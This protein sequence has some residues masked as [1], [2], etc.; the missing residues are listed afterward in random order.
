M[1]MLRTHDDKKISNIARV[2][3]LKGKSV[4]FLFLSFMSQIEVERLLLHGD[5][6]L[7][8]RFWDDFEHVYQ[9]KFRKKKVL[10]EFLTLQSDSFLTRVTSS[11]RLCNT[12]MAE[13][14]VISL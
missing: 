8:C 9:F 5:V 2:L 4:D 11:G 6:E 7:C 10:Q 13:Y 14:I 1:P 12:N 3:W